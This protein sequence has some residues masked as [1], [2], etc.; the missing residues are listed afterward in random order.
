MVTEEKLSPTKFVTEWTFLGY[1]K[2][3]DFIWLIFLVSSPPSF[4][5]MRFPHSSPMNTSQG[6]SS[7]FLML[8]M[9][10]QSSSSSTVKGL[11]F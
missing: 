9:S 6:E 10:I 11:L 3:Y 7:K 8:S 5:T 1:C 2:T 4:A